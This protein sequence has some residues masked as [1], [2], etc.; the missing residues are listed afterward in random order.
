MHAQSVADIEAHEPFTMQYR[1]ERIIFLVAA[2]LIGS[3]RLKVRCPYL[4]RARHLDTA[5]CC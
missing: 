5:L 3:A 2:P 4:P 1:L